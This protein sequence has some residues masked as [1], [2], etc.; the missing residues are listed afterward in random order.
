[1]NKEFRMSYIK[2]VLRSQLD[3][4]IL[5]KIVNAKLEKIWKLANNRPDPATRKANS[6]EGVSAVE[7]QVLRAIASAQGFRVFIR[8]KK[9]APLVEISHG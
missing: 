7:K 8:P 5:Y 1:M 6:L 2:S 9:N 4:F 3:P